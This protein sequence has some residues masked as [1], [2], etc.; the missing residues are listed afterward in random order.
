MFGLFRGVPS[1]VKEVNNPYGSNGVFP[2]SNRKGIMVCGRWSDEIFSFIKNNNIK[3]VYLNV[4]N[5]WEGGDYR[6]LSGLTSIEELNIIDGKT[7]CLSGLASM[8]SLKN[9][10]ISCHTTGDV[11]FSKLKNLQYCYLTWWTGANSLFEV[12]SLEGLYL[13]EAKLKDFSVVQNLENLHSLIIG[14]SSV[15]SL[16]WLPKLKKLSRLELLNAKKVEDFTPIASCDRLEKLTISGCPKLSTLEFV[17]SLQHLKLLNISDSHNIE[18]LK[19]LSNV[20]SLK[21]VAFA[22]TKTNILDGDLSVLKG[23]PNLSMLMFLDRKHY[24]HKLIKQWNWENFD[25]PDVLLQKK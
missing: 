20:N 3:A 5:G 2:A 11:D 13:N 16:E 8:V 25:K 1:Y 15:T 21:A 4:S 24:S 22:G 19:P 17:S 12:I 6:F 7:P 9:L 10:S 23:L 14:N 18:S